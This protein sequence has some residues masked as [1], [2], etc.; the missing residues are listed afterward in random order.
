MRKCPYCG[1][2]MVFET[3]QNPLQFIG[4]CDNENC[5]V[6]PC[7]NATNPTRVMAEIEAMERC[8]KE[9]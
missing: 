9:E 3:Y 4:Y 5:T 1:E 2:P 8:V 6:M 7:T